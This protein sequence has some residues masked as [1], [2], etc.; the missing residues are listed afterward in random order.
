MA[1]ASMRPAHRSSTTW[2]AMSK[3]KFWPAFFPACAVKNC[4]PATW[5]VSRYRKN[6][7]WDHQHMMQNHCQENQNLSFRSFQHFYIYIYILHIYKYI[8]GWN[9]DSL[10]GSKDMISQS[11]SAY[12]IWYHALKTPSLEVRVHVIQPLKDKKHVPSGKQPHMENHHFWWVTQLFRLGHLYNSY[13]AVY[14]R[15][16]S[17][18]MLYYGIYY[19]LLPGLLMVIGDYT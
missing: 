18:T 6:N 7:P 11:A 4:D 5:V 10:W 12:D 1:A 3:E 2:V 15:V 9:K 13:V 16:H 19:V 14:Q 8:C 17:Y